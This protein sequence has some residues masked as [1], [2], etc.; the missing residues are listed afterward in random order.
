MDKEQMKEFLF[1]GVNLY[2]TGILLQMQYEVKLESIPNQEDQDTL[3]TIKKE[4][5]KL[6]D[7]I[8]HFTREL[9]R[10]D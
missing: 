8:K 7:T 10:N 6:L 4:N 2:T 3:K 1:K 5:K 9:E